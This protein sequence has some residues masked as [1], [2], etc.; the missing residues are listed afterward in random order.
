[1]VRCSCNFFSGIRE[2]SL[3]SNKNLTIKV[4]LDSRLDKQR[5]FKV[6]SGDRYRTCTSKLGQPAHG[7]FKS[8]PVNE[9]PQPINCWRAL[10]KEGSGE[11][12]PGLA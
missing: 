1:M 4:L 2:D 10:R 8:L 6:N 5:K 11:T 7:I 3:A 9:C 12:R